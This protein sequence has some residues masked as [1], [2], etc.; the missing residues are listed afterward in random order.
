MLNSRAM[1]FKLNN[2]WGGQQ[3][4]PIP[5]FLICSGWALF[6][7]KC[8][9]FREKMTPTNPKS[10]W[11]CTYVRGIFTVHHKYL[12]R[13]K[14]MCSVKQENG[15][16]SGVFTLPFGRLSKTDEKQVLQSNLIYLNNITHIISENF[17][18]ACNRQ[19]T[20]AKNCGPQFLSI[21]MNFI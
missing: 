20:V 9:Q 16:W 14:K 7:P 2:H 10:T 6:Y 18:F 8:N 4:I 11:V 15:N 12:N 17:I 19:K 5:Y 13:K 1:H 21:F 3:D